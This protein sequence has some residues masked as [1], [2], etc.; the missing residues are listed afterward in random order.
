LKEEV[1]YFRQGRR[2]QDL[3]GRKPNLVRIVGHVN[4]ASTGREPWPGLTQKDHFSVRWSGSI[5]VKSAGIY[6]FLIRSDDGSKLYVDNFLIANNDG[7]HGMRNKAGQKSLSAGKHALRLEFFEKGGGAGMVFMYKGPD[8]QNKRIVV[9]QWVLEP[10]SVPVP[11]VKGGLKE[12]VFYFRQG[13]RLQD[14]NGRKPNLVRTVAN[15]DYTS[16]GRRAWPGLSRKDHFSV[17]WSGSLRVQS[18]GSYKFLIKSDD[19]SNLYIDGVLVAN[20]DGLHGMRSKKGQK[21]LSRGKHALRLEFFEKGGGAGMILMYQ[22]PDTRNQ[23]IVVP[24]WVLDPKSV[25][26]PPMKGGLKEEVFYFK[27]GRWLKNLA[28]RRPNLVRTVPTV[29][30]ASTSRHPWPPQSKGSLFCALVR[31]ATRGERW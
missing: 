14:L 15:V 16:T 5:I 28:G 20:N 10:K 27:Q 24:Q 19:G 1:F 3:N 21:K 17:R 25:P 7:L 8:T 12:E 22:G 2:L 26:V 11:P 9:P 29:D 23:R 31:L 13:R 6:R 30:Y 4:Y 18:A